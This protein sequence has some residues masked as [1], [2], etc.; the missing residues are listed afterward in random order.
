MFKFGSDFLD[1]KMGAINTAVLIT[2]SLTMAWGVT[3]AQRGQRTIRLHGGI[4]TGGE[5]HAPSC[6]GEPPRA[7]ACHLVAVHRMLT[8]R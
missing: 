1:T 6:R 8:P 2:S 4:G 7:G 5:Y 3:C